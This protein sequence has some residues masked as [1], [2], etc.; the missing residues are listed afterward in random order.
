MLLMTSLSSETKVNWSNKR[1]TVKCEAPDPIQGLFIFVY[2]YTIPYLVRDS[3][4]KQDLNDY[5]SR[6][7]FRL[8][9]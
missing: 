5:Q 2:F 3:Q 7:D 1:H 9:Y 4:L 8:Y 6:K